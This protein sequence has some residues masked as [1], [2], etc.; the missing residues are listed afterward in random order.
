MK[1]TLEFLDKLIYIYFIYYLSNEY[2]N[3]ANKDAL[4]NKGN[5]STMNRI[6]LGNPTNNTA[7]N[8]LKTIEKQRPEVR[9]TMKHIV[10]K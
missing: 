7:T 1:E 5:P 8:D 4:E 3:Q 2:Q 10:S 9:K 6:S